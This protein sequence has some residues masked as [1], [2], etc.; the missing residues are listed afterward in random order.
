MAVWDGLL[1]EEERLVAEL[2]GYGRRAG[3]GERPAL[4]VIDVTVNFCGDRPEDI[5]ESVRRWRNSCGHAAWNAVAPIQ[6]LLTAARGTGVPVIYSAGLDT[7]PEAVY[8][9]RWADKN[10]RRGED[11]TESRRGGNEIIAPLAPALGDIVVRKTKPSV[12]FGT[13]LHSYLV[14]LQVDTLVC[15]GATTSGCVRATAVDAFSHNYRVAVVE[16]A[17]F[18][19]VP[20]RARDEPVR[21]SPEVRRRRVARGCRVV[22]AGPRRQRLPPAAVAGTRDSRTAPA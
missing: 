5:I 12:F 8:A 14:D 4:L 3:Y 1:S 10:G 22:P 18:D 11:A 21:H 6:R 20:V 17:A 7:P 13:P 19:R 9:G 15:C 16:E 2:A